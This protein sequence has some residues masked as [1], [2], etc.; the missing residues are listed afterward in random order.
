MT[1]VWL[2]LAASAA[3]G[4]ADFLGGLTSRTNSVFKVLAVSQPIGLVLIVLALVL[5]GHG[6]TITGSAYW[7][8]AAG[9]AS[10]G[11]LGCLYFSMS[12]GDMILVAP[13]A[14][15]GVVIPVIAGIASGNSIT[16]ITGGGMLLAAIGAIATT[17]SAPE[18]AEQATGGN[19]NLVAALFALGSAAGQGLFLLMLSHATNGD[20]YSA[21]CIMRL[22]SCVVTL[23]VYVGYRRR[24][25]MLAPDP[26]LPA[27][28]LVGSGPAAAAGSPLPARPLQS[29]GVNGPGRWTLALLAL[30]AVGMADALAEICFAGATTSGELST[31]A[32][33]SSLYPV[34]TMFLAMLFLRERA[35][36]IQG[37]G[38]AC[39]LVGVL[40][41]SSA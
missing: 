12:R 26:Q 1:A 9:F 33:L 35:R 28:A 41:L 38:A 34:G 14:A 20:P 32:V 29:V 23:A 3:W 25:A 18:H 24:L 5:H 7:A 13:L 2:A 17:W 21:T 39:A 40:L 4:L 10:V 37:L 36:P 15:T 6:L 8:I 16:L 30:P 19:N 11:S 27:P 31:S 22:T